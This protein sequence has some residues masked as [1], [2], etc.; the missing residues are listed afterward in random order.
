MKILDTEPDY[1]PSLSYGG[2]VEKIELMR[3]S[4]RWASA[5]DRP[6]IENLLNQCNALRDEVLHSSHTGRFLKAAEQMPVHEGSPAQRRA[7]LLE[8]EFAFEGVFGESPKLL[9]AME[10]AERAAPTPLPVL[11]D[12]DSGTGKEL[13][14]KVVHANGARAD[15]PYVSVNCGAIPENLIESELFGHVR[16]AFTGASSN[17]AGRFE[18]ANGG[19][20]FLDEIGELPLSGQVKL[21]RVLQSSEVQR[22]GSDQ[23][24]EVDTR[25]VAATNRNLRAMCDEGTFREDL[26]Y[27]LS[28]IN[29]TIPP[30]RERR[31]EIP[32][33][34][35]FLSD[36]AAVLLGRTPIRLSRRL[37]TFLQ[38][39][40]YPGNIRELRN[41]LFR[42]SCLADETAD[43]DH[44]PDNV[45][46]ASTKAAKGRKSKGAQTDE[47][48]PLAD[49]KRE[50]SDAAERE[51][52]EHG[53]R[54]T[55]G[56]VTALA[57]SVDMN[58]AH[59]Q[60]LLK[61]H[62]L[63]SKDYRPSKGGG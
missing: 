6:Q 35:E 39:Y 22:V 60:T 34:I 54:E 44:L 53:L 52:L 29:V 25:I 24:I 18:A 23:A 59:L 30:L 55:N 57:K 40:D 8:R 42:V 27:R 10:I 5:L 17:R 9:E 50:A 62:G 58:R 48:R 37:Q 3:S 16:G 7:A 36:E 15:K 19:T 46:P 1:D 12:G 11:I 2:L 43:V 51:F 28:V 41:I 26:Y 31:D 38:N 49:V 47:M 33:L 56:N 13:M 20:I 32:L 14:A 45:R 61:K 4:L 21:L 63:S